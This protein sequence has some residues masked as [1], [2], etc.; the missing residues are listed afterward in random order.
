MEG[1]GRSALGARDL[2]NGAIPSA[3]RLVP[4]AIH[5]RVEIDRVVP[6]FQ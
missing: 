6:L 4:S 5:L 1:A 3:H 2:V